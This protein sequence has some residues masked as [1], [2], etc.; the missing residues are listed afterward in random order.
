MV[1]GPILTR[2]LTIRPRRRQFY[3]ARAMY[4]LILLLLMCTAWLVVTGTQYIRDVGDS[5]RFGM[6]WFQIAAPL[7]A[8]VS[9]FAAGVIA[10]G[11]VC[12][13]KD[14]RTLDLLLMTE[15]TNRELVLGKLLGSL[16]TF[17]SMLAAGVPVFMLSALLGGIS[18]RQILLSFGVTAAAVL[19]GG[20]VGTTAAFWRE[21]TFQALAVT[22][23]ALV[24]WLALGEVVAA[25]LLGD[26][27]GGA[28]CRVWAAVFSP[29]RAVLE[30]CR[31]VPDASLSVFGLS[32][33]LAFAF[34]SVAVFAIT[35]GIAVLRVRTWNLVPDAL[36]RRLRP[37]ELKTLVEGLAGAAQGSAESSVA[38]EEAAQDWATKW[39]TRGRATAEEEDGEAGETPRDVPVPGDAATTV[40]RE[41]AKVRHVWDNPVLWR[42][43]CTWAYGRKVLLVKGAYLTLFA[44][45]AA[46]LAFLQRPEAGFSILPA[47]V[48]VPLFLLSLILVNTQ[49]V[50]ALTTER[51][52]GTLDLILVSQVTPK[53]FV[54]GKLLGTF[55]NVKEVVILPLLLCGYL[56]WQGRVSAEN[57]FY[58]IVGLGLL[59]GFVAMLGLHAGLTYP[60]SRN[61]IAASLGTV[62]FLFVGV[63]VCMRVML[64]FSGSFQAQLHPFLAFMI[65]GGAGLYLALGS[66]NPSNAIALA[67]F[68][69]PLATFYALTSLFLGQTHL[70]FLALTGA[71]GFATAAMLIP[72]VDE[73]DLATGR[74][75]LDET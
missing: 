15:L 69:C 46:A 13:E 51:D 71:Y 40:V 33:L 26:S 43:V 18:E 36:R 60:S 14:R 28:S 63:A 8:L 24:L 22:I 11:S 59:Y 4:V 38:V 32:P 44:A 48:L 53:E 21:K 64:A 68:A 67:S 1:A 23:M 29:W 57:F 34:F 25:G 10:A 75:S 52:A 9:F 20:A 73:F 74:T 16:V 45:A 61:A 3:V 70:A 56:Y 5:A 47:A 6:A 65:G 50:T 42:E 37:A 49:A 41:K 72:A 30:S 31:P 35:A 17:F 12:Q 55:Y 62:F 39:E 66:R 54:F 2:E 19:L 7:Q 27:W 58:L